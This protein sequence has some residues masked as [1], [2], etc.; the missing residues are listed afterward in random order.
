MN[1]ADVSLFHW[2]NGWSN[3][4]A[5]FFDF[6]SEGSKMW[7]VRIGLGILFIAMITAGIRTRRPALLAILAFPLA[8]FICDLLKNNLQM[9]R[10]C[11]PNGVETVINHGVGFLGSYG[12]AS[13]HA[14]NTSAIATVFFYFLAWKT[15]STLR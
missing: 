1:G 14:A 6:L 2:I 11:P 7:P 15:D 8:N 4:Y 5:P 10:P 12:T 9:A 13:A 3:A